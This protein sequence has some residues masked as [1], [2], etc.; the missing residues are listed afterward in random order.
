[1]EKQ[2][3]LKKSIRTVKQDVE[4]LYTSIHNERMMRINTLGNFQN[5]PRQMNPILRMSNNQYHELPH[6]Y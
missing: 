5:A 3:K 2:L 6:I 4:Q 1:M